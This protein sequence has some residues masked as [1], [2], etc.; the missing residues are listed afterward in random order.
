MISRT[1][2]L[3]NFEDLVSLPDDF[4]QVQMVTD[5]T[6]G[7]NVIDFFSHPITLKVSSGRTDY[8][9][10]AAKV[11]VRQ[12]NPRLIRKYGTT[13]YCSGKQTGQTFVKLV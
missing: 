1:G 5:P 13:T 6:R 11:N 8:Q 9:I 4:S 10:V 7:E 3:I 12:L 2:F